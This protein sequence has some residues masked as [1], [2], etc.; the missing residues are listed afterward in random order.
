[1]PRIHRHK[2]VPVQGDQL[3]SRGL[4]TRK[5]L[6]AAAR[7]VLD[8][9]GYSQMTVADVT[10]EAGVAA[11]LFHRYFPDLRT[12]TQELLDEVM[13][14][15]GDTDRIER[16]VTRGDWVGRIHSHI[17]PSVANHAL[18]PGLV[19]AMNQLAEESPEFRA[20]LRG[21]Y[22][23]Q[24]ELLSAQMPRLFPDARLTAAESLLL[25]YAIGGI[26]EVA[27]RELYILRNPALK[28][29]DLKPDELADWLAA[30]FYRALFAANPPPDRLPG[31][32]RL[33][34]IKRREATGPKKTSVSSKKRAASA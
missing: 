9:K 3:G 16:G 23:V 34:S 27:L 14:E 32:A 18:R 26:S 6:T 29:L 28:N 15:L 13:T 5:R 4:A 12:L 20:R 19:R 22:Q 24:L 21:F 2:R 17:V 11:G 33:L 30:L 7:R 10:G 31:A 1:M 8:R 25:A